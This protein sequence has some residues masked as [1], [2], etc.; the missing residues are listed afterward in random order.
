[1]AAQI[2]KTSDIKL[3]EPSVMLELIIR[4]RLLDKYYYN[5]IKIQ[6]LPSH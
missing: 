5:L 6:L 2:F 4:Y 1:M 3:M